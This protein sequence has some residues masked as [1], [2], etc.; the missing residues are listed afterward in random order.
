MTEGKTG[1]RIRILAGLV[2]FLF[3]ALIT[4]LWFLQVLA[5]EENRERAER[6]RVRLVPEQAQRGR[7][8]DRRGT[9]L[10]DNR[11]S[12]VVTV[13]RDE[14]EDTDQLLFN[15][16]QLLGIP[17]ERLLERMSGLNYLPF[18]PIPVAL[19]VT[20]EQAF[21]I[22]EFPSRFP[23]VDVKRIPVR[24][25][26]LDQS[27]VHLLGYTGEISQEE[28]DDPAFAGYDPGDRIG[29]SGVER[30]YEEFLRGID[31]YQKLQINAQGRNLGPLGPR[32]PPIPGDDV[33][34]S[35]D[36]EVQQLTEESLALGIAAARDYLESSGYLRAT[37]GA[38]VVLDPNTGQVLAMTSFPEYDPKQF[39]GRV[40]DRELRE[41]NSPARHF[42][43]INR[44][45]Q[46][47]YSPASTFKPFIALSALKRRIDIGGN[48]VTTQGIYPCPA[49]WVAPTDDQTVFGNWNPLDSGFMPLSRA[50]AE[51]CDTVFYPMGFNFWQLYDPNDAEPDEPLQED[52][53]LFGFDKPTLVDIPYEHSGRIPDAAWKRE[54]HKADPTNPNAI[55][56]PGD[57]V[58]MT[59]GQ[60]DALVT[61]LQ[62]AVAYSAIANG[63]TVYAPHVVLRIQEPDGDVIRRI[64]PQVTGTLEGFT[65]RQL[66]YVRDALQ[67]VVKDGGTAT[68]AFA[69]FPLNE[70]PVAGKTGTT[71]SNVAGRQS[72]SWFVAMAPA[73]DPQYVVVAVVEQGG[74]GSTTAA[75]VVRR[76]L[77]GLF[78]LTTSDLTT[79]VGT[80]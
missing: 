63:G 13:N 41:L 11:Q 64:R 12:L 40:T 46:A 45:I 8:L 21:Q 31:G 35:I 17:V 61:P 60:G 36:T 54:F 48:V 5:A 26:P 79:G 42:P 9:V 75:P 7:I 14:V 50:L 78:G 16:Q 80:D 62:M 49:T 25:Y 51:S 6:N 76:I 4:R 44:A 68:S 69:G 32:T 22:E 58:N 24:E 72:D 3:A 39:L 2:V 55:W 66:R 33:V 59:I 28:L 34:L 19:D 37:G 77:E 57:V 67:G 20:L 65:P 53:R 1:H 15:L 73:N 29:Q 71:E 18:T 56:Y 47:D 23:G 38:A 27:A 70:I 10:V 43:L 52:L 74:H 30:S